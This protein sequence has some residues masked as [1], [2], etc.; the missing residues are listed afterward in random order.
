[1]ALRRPD[2]IFLSEDI[3]ES[4]GISPFSC[5][6]RS[7]PPWPPARPTCSTM[8]AT[9]A[10]QPSDGVT[11]TM[12]D[13]ECHASRTI[14]A[15]HAFFSRH[16]PHVSATHRGCLE[17]IP[18]AHLA[19]STF[20]IH[21]PPSRGASAGVVEGH[22]L[23]RHVCGSWRSSRS[24]SQVPKAYEHD[25]HSYETFRNGAYVPDPQLFAAPRA[26][27][28]HLSAEPFPVPGLFL[29]TA[30]TGWCALSAS[31]RPSVASLVQIERR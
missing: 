30:L 12:F 18:C 14:L 16:P 5:C 21:P 3:R 25:I 31:L 7:T 9:D 24:T 28:A 19:R 10:P 27:C 2:A 8:A 20:T 15:M 4:V 22:H 26:A 1:M 17:L 6:S 23:P 29:P 11:T 13:G